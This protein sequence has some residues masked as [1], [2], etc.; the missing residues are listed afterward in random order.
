MLKLP[1][2]VYFQEQAGKVWADL[3]SENILKI[4]FKRRNIDKCVF[5]RGIL[6]FLVYV[7]EGIFFSLDGISIDSAIKELKY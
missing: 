7:D 2:N 6:V 4:V 3:L 1:R 5:Y